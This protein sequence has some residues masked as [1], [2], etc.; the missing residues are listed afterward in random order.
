MI[1]MHIDTEEVVP[2]E[3]KVISFAIG[4]MCF[5]LRKNFAESKGEITSK[6]YIEILQR[7][8]EQIAAINDIEI[9]SS[10]TWTLKA[11]SLVGEEAIKLL[12]DIRVQFRINIPERMQD[13]LYKEIYGD[14]QNNLI[15]SEE[16]LVKI[17]DTYY[18]PILFVRIKGDNQYREASRAL[19]L[20]REYLIKELKDRNSKIDVKILG[21]TPFHADFFLGPDESKNFD[22]IY[23]FRSDV[24]KARGYDS[25]Y[26][27][28]NKD[29]YKD[30][31]GAY[32]D[33]SLDISQEAEIFY[34]IRSND[35]DRINEWQILNN[36]MDDVIN[37][38]GKFFKKQLS[39][40]FYAKRIEKVYSSIYSFG[41]SSALSSAVESSGFK[42]VYDA[43][44]P[45]HIKYVVEKEIS[46]SMQY[47]VSELMKMI[48]FLENRRSK[49]IEVIYLAIS[50]LIGAGIGAL[51][52]YL[53][54]NKSAVQA[55]AAS[56]V[57]SISIPS[58]W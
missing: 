24:L 23:G 42:S 56:S 26:A 43:D 30:I 14:E 57:G 13:S 34:M 39:K 52:T 18:F 51:I 2:S 25:I 47:P 28:Y 19:V 15:K 55:V 1:E 7:E 50:T 20:V 21:P 27:F 54:A 38:E 12:N 33:L 35:H 48:E 37:K 44:K 9:T 29:D 10:E 8:L 11:E 17:E 16:F 46:T 32:N 58:L 31:E 3:G 45:H 41:V 6:E 53:V 36:Q 5:S 22:G 40:L 49:N 4:C